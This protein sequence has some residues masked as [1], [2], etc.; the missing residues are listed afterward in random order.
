M[1]MSRF[2]PSFQWLVTFE[3]ILGKLV[4]FRP[5]TLEL[6]TI[7]FVTVAV[8]AMSVT[9]RASE[10][11]AGESHGSEFNASITSPCDLFIVPT[12]FRY[13]C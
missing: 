4:A 7:R 1:K 9:H 10:F 8:V 6:V 3:V 2:G 5:V 13:L 11:R 12:K